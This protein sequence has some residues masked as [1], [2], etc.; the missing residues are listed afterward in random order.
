MVSFLELLLSGRNFAE[1]D[2]LCGSFEDAG[3]GAALVF[4]IWGGL[5]V[6]LEEGTL[7]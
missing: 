5:D 1:C 4:W 2:A 7:K 6:K 3:W